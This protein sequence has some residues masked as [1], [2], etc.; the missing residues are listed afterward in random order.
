MENKNIND[1]NATVNSDGLTEKAEEQRVIELEKEK[2]KCDEFDWSNE[3]NKKILKNHNMVSH[4]KVGFCKE[5]GR[6]ELIQFSTGNPDECEHWECMKCGGE[7]SEEEDE[8][9]TEKKTVFVTRV[10][11]G[12]ESTPEADREY[13]IDGQGPVG[14]IQELID[15]G[16]NPVIE[17]RK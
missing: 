6:K 5:C 16:Y 15:A 14:T 7:W 12:K 1:V 10:S 17:V 11:Y 4:W 2:I 13:Q 3:N 9:K 8:I